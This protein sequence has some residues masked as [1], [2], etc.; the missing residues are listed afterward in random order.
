VLRDRRWRLA[1]EL[2]RRSRRRPARAQPAD[3]RGRRRAAGRLAVRHPGRR[4]RA[5]V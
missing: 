1:G 2:G 4:G 5:A 3:P